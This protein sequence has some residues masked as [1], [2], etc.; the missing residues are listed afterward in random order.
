M[1][2]QSSLDL[3]LYFWKQILH[4]WMET[5]HWQNGIKAYNNVHHQLTEKWLKLTIK[6]PLWHLNRGYNELSCW[7]SER[8]LLLLSVLKSKMPLA[9]ICG[10]ALENQSKIFAFTK[11]ESNFGFGPLNKIRAKQKRWWKSFL[12]KI[13]TDRTAQTSK[14]ELLSNTKLYICYDWQFAWKFQICSVVFY[15]AKVWTK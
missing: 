9:K 1:S 6:R 12:I 4:Q 13:K 7:W 10:G 11:F 5:F 15:K 14:S 3:L 2:L 8:Q